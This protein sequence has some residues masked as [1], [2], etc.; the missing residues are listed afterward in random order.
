MLRDS[1]EP[2]P[3]PGWLPGAHLQEADIQLLSFI[4]ITF[5]R[6]AIGFGSPVLPSWVRAW[7]FPVVALV[8][9]LGSMKGNTKSAGS[10][11]HKYQSR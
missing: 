4:V 11:C 6:A 10:L 9:L 3:R 7:L 2:R 5:A 8:L 1:P